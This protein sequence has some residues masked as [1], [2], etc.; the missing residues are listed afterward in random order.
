M[1][2]K[3]GT[4]LMPHQRQ[5]LD[6]GLETDPETG[7][8]AYREVIVT[9]PR[10]M[11]KTVLIFSVELDRCC[12]WWERQRVI[13]SAQT[14]T[15]ARR[16]LI[17][18][19]KP[20]LKASPLWGAVAKVR[21]AQ[22]NE[23]FVFKN[24]SL[25][26]V[27][28][29]SEESGHGFAVDLGVVD[30]AWKDE[31][32]RRE[33]SMVPAMNTRPWAQLWVCSTQGTARS[34]YLN[35]KTEVGRHAAEVDKGR[36]I[37]YFEWSIP[38]EADIEDPEVWWQYLPALGWT[39]TPAAVAHALESMEELEWRRAYGN[40]QT[41]QATHRVIPLPI[42]DSAQDALAE[43]ARDRRVYFG[44]D[45]HPERTSGAIAASDGRVVELV[46]HE[47][48]TGWLAERAKAVHERWGGQFVIDGGGP[49][50]SLVD[51]L[52]SAG[53]PVL[54]LSNA[55][56]VK[57]CARMYD[58]LADGRVMVRTAPALDAAVEGLAKRPVGDRF[59]WSRSV[60]TTDITP[61]YAATL[62]LGVSPEREAAPLAAWT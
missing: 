32:N 1:A 24:G 54:Q 48:G 20:M 57:A 23:S 16:K 59:V 49:A 12:M 50:A 6:V 14:G 3:L 34:A 19:Q 38:E 31:D 35:R 60:S 56:V 21:E 18:D 8:F 51:D 7:L 39:I 28:A 40:Q 44:L 61:F 58:N 47:Q 52:E 11:G 10:Q 41:K 55:D 42:W 4:P 26:T 37:A 5:V 53:V 27:N 13:Y 17:E 29:K 36:G 9:M 33:Q 22:G 46:A 45:V 2:D 25:I 62:A 43:V 15:D 30:E